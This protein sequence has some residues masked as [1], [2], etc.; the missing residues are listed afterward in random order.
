MTSDNIKPAG[1]L[2][3]VWNINIYLVRKCTK[4]TLIC[5]RCRSSWTTFTTKV[6]LALCEFLFF[7][8]CT[9]SYKLTGCVRLY[10]FNSDLNKKMFLY[11]NI[12]AVATVTTSSVFSLVE[13]PHSSGSSHIF[14]V[15]FWGS[16]AG[17]RELSNAIRSAVG[18]EGLRFAWWVPPADQLKVGTRKG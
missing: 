14:T 12:W 3:E 6:L 10:G 7:F 1:F 13:H 4:S 9:N 8:I 16:V 5:E 17:S 11:C 2:T 15:W 18:K